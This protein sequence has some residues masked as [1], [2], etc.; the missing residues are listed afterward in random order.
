MSTPSRESDARAVPATLWH[1][2]GKKPRSLWLSTS[3]A[4]IT[5]NSELTLSHI[6]DRPSMGLHH[7]H[8]TEVL[9]Y[10]GAAPC[11][12]GSCLELERP[13]PLC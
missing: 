2:S 3:F 1:G 10:R 5:S 12:R 13:R 6:G 9:D 7:S 11:V 4:R 8:V